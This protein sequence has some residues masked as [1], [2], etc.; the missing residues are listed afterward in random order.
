MHQHLMTPNL[1]LQETRNAGAALAVAW[2][3]KSITSVSW[4]LSSNSV[5]PNLGRKSGRQA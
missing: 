3:P 4:G 1:T 5:A 2:K